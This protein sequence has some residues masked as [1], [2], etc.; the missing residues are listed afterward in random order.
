MKFIITLIFVAALVAGGYCVYLGLTQS[1]NNN[2]GMIA[3]DAGNL[4]QSVTDTF[5][6]GVDVLA[7]KANERKDSVKAKAE[8]VK[9]T[10]VVKISSAAESTKEVVVEKI[11]SAAES[12]SL[13]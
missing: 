2:A 11:S 5:K 6:D 7:K 3:L 12:G 1:G 10:V 9:D 13:R 8:S 4:A